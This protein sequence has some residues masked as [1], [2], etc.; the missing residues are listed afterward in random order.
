MK[1]SIV[2]NPYNPPNM[3]C[4]KFLVPCSIFIHAVFKPIPYHFNGKSYGR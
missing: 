2:K 4:K 1:E 3:L